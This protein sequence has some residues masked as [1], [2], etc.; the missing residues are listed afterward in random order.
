MAKT[1]RLP[2]ETSVARVL[3]NAGRTFRLCR[4][5]R[6]AYRA[7]PSNVGAATRRADRTLAAWSVS[8][9]VAFIRALATGAPR[10]TLVSRARAYFRALKAWKAYYAGKVAK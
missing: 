8:R 6:R 1:F 4:A 7:E 2:R 9:K 5:A 3:S 10:K